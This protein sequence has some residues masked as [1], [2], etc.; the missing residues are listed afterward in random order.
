[1]PVPKRR[2]GRPRK[3]EALDEDRRR[4]LAERVNYLYW[5]TSCSIA[6]IARNLGVSPGTVN[7]LLVDRETYEAM[8]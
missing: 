7:A 1:M 6:R 2:R 8:M 5:G 4:V 3:A